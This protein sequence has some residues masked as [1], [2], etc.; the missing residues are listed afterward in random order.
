MV[1]AITVVTLIW[2]F[3]GGAIAFPWFIPI[4]AIIAI[5]VGWTVSRLGTP[6][7]RSKV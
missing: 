7:E 6:A 4:G 1:S 5:A 3:G 2:K